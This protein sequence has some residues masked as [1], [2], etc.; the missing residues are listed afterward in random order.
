MSEEQR[1]LGLGAL[2]VALLGVAV[3]VFATRSAEREAFPNVYQMEGVCLS[4]RQED[5]ASYKQGERPPAECP[6][7]GQRT[8][9]Q[10]TFCFECNKRFV[11][12]PVPSSDGGPPKPPVIPVCTA[13]GSSRT[14][15]YDPHDPE[16]QSVGD[17][18][19]PTL[20]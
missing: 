9:Y 10:W 19:L 6:N 3:Y 12:T 18:D 17:A 16:Q 4:C 13:C 8:V 14:G 5:Q 7:C 2:A 11:A 1:N 20:P 15:A